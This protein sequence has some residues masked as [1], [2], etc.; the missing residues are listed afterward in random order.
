MKLFGHIKQEVMVRNR[1][2]KNMI[3]YFYTR[4]IQII[5]LIQ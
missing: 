4:K 5:F 3:H 1:L 2:V